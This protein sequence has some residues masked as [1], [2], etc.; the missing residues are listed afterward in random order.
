[1]FFF[2]FVGLATSQ[3]FTSAKELTWSVLF[4]SVCHSD[5]EQDYWISTEPISLKFDVMHGPTNQKNWLTFGEAPFP[6]TNSGSLFRFPR[7]CGIGDFEIV[8]LIQSPADFYDTLRNSRKPD[9]NPRLLWVDVRRLG[10]GLRSL[11]TFWFKMGSDFLCDNGHLYLRN[12][13]AITRCYR[14]RQS[15]KYRVS[16]FRDVDWFHQHRPDY[17]SPATLPT[18]S[19][20]RPHSGLPAAEDGT[21]PK[22][23]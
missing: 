1:M 10:G 7:H 4:L 8:F 18:T 6:D 21:R 14:Q 20:V 2:V 11:N 12:E 15:R 19:R 22:V 9:S 16:L 13:L 17:I 5:C 23:A 3:M